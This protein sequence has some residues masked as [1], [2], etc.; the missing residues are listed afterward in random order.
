MKRSLKVLAILLGLGLQGYGQTQVNLR[1]QATDIDFTGASST[2]PLQS[3]TV[4]PAT[5]TTEQLFFLTSAPSGANLYACT[6]TNVWSLETAGGGLSANA[7]VTA[8]GSNA[9]QTPNSSATMDSSGNI[10]TPGSVT[11]G[12]GSSG[13]GFLALFQGTMPAQTTFPAMSFSLVGNPSITK[14]YQWVVP[15]ADAAG[16]VVSNGAGTPGQ[17]SIKALQGTDAKLLTA[18]M[19]SGAGATLCM[20]ASGGA[21]TSGCG[22]G[23][24]SF[25]IEVG[26]FV[27]Y[28]QNSNTCA[29]KGGLQISGTG[30]VQTYCSVS[31]PFMPVIFTQNAAAIDYLYGSVWLPPTVPS[32]VT[33]ELLAYTGSESSVANMEFDLSAVCTA[34]TGNNWAKPSFPTS[35]SS[36]VAVGANQAQYGYLFSW[37]GYSLSGCSAGDTL[38]FRINR[39]NSTPGNLADWVQTYDLRIHQ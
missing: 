20:D 30:Q 26:P 29:L 12:A 33:F 7:L 27:G 16:A 24:S 34:N 8:S 37:G 21:T 31:A 9:L 4:L 18:G 38:W 10:H 25:Y 28:D 11:T 5:C 13:A 1:T 32:T 35:T 3:G 23:S 6:A 14:Q 22:S 19:V 39:N 36:I 2:K 17:L 15:A